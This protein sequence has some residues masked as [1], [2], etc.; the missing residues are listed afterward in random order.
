M[1]VPRYPS[2]PVQL[3]A[4]GQVIQGDGR[5]CGFFVCTTSSLTLKLWDNFSAASGNVLLATTA[6]LS[7]GWYPC[8]VSFGVG[9]YA[10]FGGTGTVTFVYERS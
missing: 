9:V 3:A 8:P 10:T 1:A 4:T 2:V 5:L 6:A 7:V